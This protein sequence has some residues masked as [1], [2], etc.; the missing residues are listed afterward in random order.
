[1]NNNN[2]NNNNNINN[3][4]NNNNNNKNNNSNNNNNNNKKDGGLRPKA[5][6]Y[7][8]LRLAAKCANKYAI[9]KLAAQLAPIQ[10]G[11]GIPSGAEA[12]VHALR[13]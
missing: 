13:L 6:G 3:N 2:N 11:V 5:I 10:L 7:T 9:E 1:M 4:N 12:A 8:I